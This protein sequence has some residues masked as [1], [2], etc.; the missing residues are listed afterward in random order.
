MIRELFSFICGWRE[1]DRKCYENA[2][3]LYGGS[4]NTHPG[5]VDFINSENNHKLRYFIKKIRGETIAAI[6]TNDK[7]ELCQPQSRTA[8][9]H[10]S[11]DEVIFPAKPD[12]LFVLPFKSKYISE[13]NRENIINLLPN[14]F[15]KRYVCIVKNFFCSKT[16]KRRRNEINFFLRNGGEIRCVK[17][18]SP[19]EICHI[20]R[21]LYIMRWGE[22][23]DE[24]YFNSLKKF[25]NTCP[26]V[27]FGHVLL[28]DKKPCAIDYI[29]KT[30]SPKWLY[31]D[32][33]NGGLDPAYK[34]LSL[35]SVLMW[36]NIQ[37]ARIQAQIAQKTVRFNLGNPTMEYKKR[38]T[39][40]HK[41]YR[42][43]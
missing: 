43:L 36:L 5:I 40:C 39:L 24:S 42:T 25:L 3:M 1:C 7:M 37:E 22:K 30:D 38:W 34:S 2:Y 9:L 32:V 28:I 19:S 11:F 18:Y 23:F 41:L 27:L 33:V 17:D 21:N 12:T 6:F 13:V 8:H 20:Y 16:H 26:E 29:V 15:N 35:G 31:F 14:I 4:S 10:V